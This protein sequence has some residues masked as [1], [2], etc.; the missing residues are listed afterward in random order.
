MCVLCVFVT[1]SYGV[2]GQVWYLIVWIPDLCLLPYIIQDPLC[3]FNTLLGEIKVIHNKNMNIS[4]YTPSYLSPHR[5][6]CL[7][8]MGVD[9][10][11]LAIF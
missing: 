1:F 3:V 11:L 4:I 8:S 10:A 9:D 5:N 7:R 6:S 2:L